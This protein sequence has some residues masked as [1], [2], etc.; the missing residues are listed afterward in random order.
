LTKYPDFKRFAAF[1][2]GIRLCPGLE[3]AEN[4]LLIEAVSLFWACNVCKKKDEN[5]K[6][7]GVP[8]HDYSGTLIS[9]P[10]EFEFVLQE[11]VEGRLDMMEQ[12]AERDHDAELAA[13]EAYSC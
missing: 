13:Q 1:G 7:I 2:H 10:R 8:F 4:S 5:G 11:R 9:M 3:V 6:E 12:A